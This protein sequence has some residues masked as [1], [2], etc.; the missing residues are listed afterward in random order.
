MI[1]VTSM[2]A[3]YPFGLLLLASSVLSAEVES[4][5]TV[6]EYQQGQHVLEMDGLTHSP[7]QADLDWS[8]IVSWLILILLSLLVFSLGYYCG[9][10]RTSRSSSRRDHLESHSSNE[11]FHQPFGASSG[12]MIPY[13]VKLSSSR[14]DV[15][16]VY[17]CQ[18]VKQTLHPST[19]RI[20]KHCLEM[21][22]TRSYVHNVHKRQD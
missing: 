20:C 4:T 17:D 12:R 10:R 9:S 3:M 13:K 1:Q 19:L 14:S 2:V 16:H 15:F 5:A 8:H 18:A 11:E 22:E 7:Y 21:H 6:E